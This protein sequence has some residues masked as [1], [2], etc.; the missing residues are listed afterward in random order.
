M[1]DLKLDT[2]FGQ[3]TLQRRPRVPG[4]RAWDG[5]DEYLLEQ[6]A[7]TPPPHTSLVINDNFGA[8]TCALHVTEP[9]SWG[10]SFVAHHATADNWRRN[11]L[12]DDFTAL[13]A[14]ATPPPGFD[15]VLWRVP[16][17]QTLFEQQIARLHGV[18]TPQ[19]RI[20]AGGM[21]KHLLPRTRELLERLGRVDTLPGRRKAHLFELHPDPSLPP[22][23]PPAIAVTRL[24][25]HDLSLHNDANLFAREQ[26]DIGARFFIEQ[27]P[28]LPPAARVAD[29]GA[30]NGVLALVLARLRPDREIH[31]FDESYQARAAALDNWQRNIGEP[32]AERFHVGDALS[33]YTGTPFDLV[34]CNPPFHQQHVI[35]GHIAR[36]M[37][38]GSHTHLR[39]GGELWVV[40]NRHLDYPARLRQLFGNCRQ[41]AAGNKFVVL[42]ATR[43]KG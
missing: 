37:F 14:T 7:A 31:L 39:R 35:G 20:L 23:P 18:I 5:A 15:L 27:F 22:P 16:K 1:H 34:L 11:N 40:A 8:L 17:S 30:G 10:D 41:V 32:V 3:L 9:V 12:P 24:P 29:V 6:A 13:P 28:R 38:A 25:E 36:R 33:G 43:K 2:P 26:L 19:T 42:A 21:D 4:L